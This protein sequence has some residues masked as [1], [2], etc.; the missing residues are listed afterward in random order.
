[1]PKLASESQ[2][3]NSTSFDSRRGFHSVA[4]DDVVSD[5]C[6]K[7]EVCGASVREAIGNLSLRVYCLRSVELDA[8]EIS[9][10]LAAFGRPVLG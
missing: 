1:M 3:V 4:C 8:S 9:C 5:H 2:M 7:R 10:V 6:Q